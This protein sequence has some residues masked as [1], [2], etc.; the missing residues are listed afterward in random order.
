MSAIHD[1]E[2]CATLISEII[3]LNKT[4]AG[5]PLRVHADRHALLHLRHHRH[6]T[7]RCHVP[8]SRDTDQPTQQLPG[9]FQSVDVVVQ[10]GNTQR[11][12][13]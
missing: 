1:A 7:V 5:P 9:L 2:P 12:F 11:I 13:P 8:G 3:S 4:P 6:A 10:V